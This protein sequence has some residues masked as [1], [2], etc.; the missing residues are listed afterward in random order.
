MIER[1]RETKRK[2][3]RNT[4]IDIFE[5]TEIGKSFKGKEKEREVKERKLE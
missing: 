1:E 5:K 2:S 4:T 3:Q